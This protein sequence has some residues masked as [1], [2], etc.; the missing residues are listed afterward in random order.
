MSRPWERSN[1]MRWQDRRESSNIEDRRGDDSGTGGGFNFPGGGGGLGGLPG[2]GGG[3]MSLG[4]IGIV[5][6]ILAVAWF[7]G[8][9]PTKL[10]GGGMGSGGL[11]FPS[12]AGSGSET[13]KAGTPT[14][15]QGKFV[16]SVLGDTEDAWTAIFKAAGKTYEPP[17]LVLFSGQT[18]SGCGTASAAVGPFYCPNDHKLYI[19]LAFYDELSRRFGA[20]GDF[21]EA[22]VI[23][24]EVGH[25]VQNLLGILPQVDAKRRQVS[26]AESNE[27]SVRL[28][29]QADCFAG[30]WGNAAQK[31]GILEQGDFEEALNAAAAVG[32]DRLQKQ[33]QGYVVPDSFTHGTSAQRSAWFKKGFTAGNI[34]ACD[35]FSGAI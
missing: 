22:Y 19:D 11:Q 7:A 8:I 17:T 12:G 14:D 1:D 33:S 5:L 2:G 9:D 21:A 31:E 10:L 3:R 20:P 32:D 15:Q 4:G 29:L 18:S 24:H 16:A 27:L 28:E 6:V 26:E 35:T 34:N 23:A 30:V 25:H 13:G